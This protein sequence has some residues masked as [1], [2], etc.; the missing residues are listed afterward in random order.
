MIPGPT[1][2]LS[3]IGGLEF[4]M[5]SPTRSDEWYQHDEKWTLSL[6]Q[7]GMRVRLFQKRKDGVFFRAVWV[8]GSGCDQVSLQTNDRD[9]AERLGRELLAELQEAKAPLSVGVVRMG[10]LARRYQAECTTHLDNTPR[11]FTYEASL[12]E[13]MVRFFGT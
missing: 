8:P 11:T 6:G 7:R 2:G 1:L 9:E 10:E 4:L 3:R 13:R 12:I 5:A